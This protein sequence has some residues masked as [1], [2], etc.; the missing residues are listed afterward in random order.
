MPSVHCAHFHIGPT[1]DQKKTVYR[2]VSKVFTV[3][4]VIVKCAIA[5][6]TFNGYYCW[7]IGSFFIKTTA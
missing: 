4:L 5:C 3:K 6:F 1:T 7:V 2:L